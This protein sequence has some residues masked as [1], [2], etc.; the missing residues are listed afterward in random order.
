MGIMKDSLEET[1]QHVENL[2]KVQDHDVLTKTQ[3]QLMRWNLKQ[4]ASLATLKSR[5][6][7]KSNKKQK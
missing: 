7:N 5:I 1:Q 6:A 2:L 3:L 4:F